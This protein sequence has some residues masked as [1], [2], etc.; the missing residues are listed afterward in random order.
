MTR[1]RRPAHRRPTEPG[2]Y[3]RTARVNEL[4]RE[5]LAEELERV[6]DE[7]LELVTIT[8]VEVDPD[9]RHARVEFSRLGQDEDTAAAALGEH[10]VPLQAAIAR[11]ARLRRTPELSFR[12][13]RTIEAGARI[14]KLLGDVSPAPEDPGD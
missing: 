2:R 3:P 8:H 9:L 14:E 5:I 11:Q 10:R 12:R 13:D 6:D 4:C 7:R 1:R